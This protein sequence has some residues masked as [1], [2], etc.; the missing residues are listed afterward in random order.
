MASMIANNG[1]HIKTNR[2]IRFK[3]LKTM[4]ADYYQGDTAFHFLQAA[5]VDGK[6]YFPFASSSMDSIV[7]SRICSV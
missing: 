5:V 3:A 7:H 4:Y 1:G 6:F 2:R